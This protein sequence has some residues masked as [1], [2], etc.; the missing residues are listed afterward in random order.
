[1][2]SPQ[3][4]GVATQSLHVYVEN[5]DA[6]FERAL[7]AGAEITSPPKDTDFGS[8]EYH[9]R[10]LEGHLWTFGTYR[11]DPDGGR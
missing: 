8:R 2:A 1:M 5:M 7:S 4:T 11:P 3:A 10:D 9:V 6:H